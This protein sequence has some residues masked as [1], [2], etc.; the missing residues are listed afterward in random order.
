MSATSIKL[1]PE[2]ETPLE[3]LSIKLDRSKNY[4]VNQAVKEFL[5]RKAREDER[6]TETLDAIDS[7]DNG[8]TV[9][10]EAVDAWLESWGADNEQDPPHR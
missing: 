5:A 7:V 6:W 3:Q 8:Q 1:Q 10:G 4:L 2:I 9:D